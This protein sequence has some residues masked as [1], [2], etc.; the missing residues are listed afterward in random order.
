MV[1]KEGLWH[2]SAILMAHAQL[3]QQFDRANKN[4]E[5]LLKEIEN[6]KKEIA[7]LKQTIKELDTVQQEIEKKRKGIKKSDCAL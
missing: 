1:S 6:Q 7:R 3:K 2:I 5:L 4:R